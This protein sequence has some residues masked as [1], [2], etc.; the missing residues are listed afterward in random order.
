MKIKV[1]K[2]I[3]INKYLTGRGTNCFTRPTYSSAVDDWEIEDVDIKTLEDYVYKG[4]GIM[5]NC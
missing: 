2:F 4:Y 5:I 1:N 3:W